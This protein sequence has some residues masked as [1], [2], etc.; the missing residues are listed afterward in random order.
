MEKTTIRVLYKSPY[1]L[2]LDKDNALVQNVAKEITY[3]YAKY[4]RPGENAT[5][6]ALSQRPAN[7]A[8]IKAL[9]EQGYDGAVQ[10]RLDVLIAKISMLM[11][12]EF[13][14]SQIYGFDSF[15]DYDKERIEKIIKSFNE[16]SEKDVKTALENSLI[17]GKDQL[18]V[19]KNV[20]EIVQK[21]Q[22][23]FENY[24]TVELKNLQLY[25]KLAHS[26]EDGNTRYIVIDNGE[27]CAEC[28]ALA[29][30][31]F[32]ISEAKIGVNC[33][34]FHPNCDGLIAVLDRDG[35]PA[36]VLGTSAELPEA[37]EIEK[38]LAEALKNAGLIGED[39]A[40]S[41]SNALK[42]SVL[43]GF[44]GYEK[45]LNSSVGTQVS[46]DWDKNIEE[47]ADYLK[48]SVNQV[49]LGNYT[50]DVT[51]LGT[52]GQ[53]A[54]GIL[55][56]DAVCDVRDFI[57]D[58]THWEWS[59][60]HI[61]Q[62]VLD[63]VAVVPIIGCF[64]YGDEIAVVLKKV[65]GNIVEFLKKSKIVDALLNSKIMKLLT[66]MLDELPTKG[67]ARL[68]TAGGPD[69]YLN[70]SLK[71]VDDLNLDKSAKNLDVVPDALK[72]TDDAA[73]EIKVAKE[74]A[75]AAK[76]EAEAAKEEIK[77][78]KK[79]SKDVLDNLENTDIFGPE[80]IEHIFEGQINKKGRAT[81]YHYNNIEGTAG[82]I[83]PE[84]KSE[85]NELGIYK[86]DVEV[87][88]VKKIRKSSF[89]PDNMNSQEVVDA[90]AEAYD[91]RSNKK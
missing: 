85:V 34:P 49:V 74:E 25:T 76:E 29:G 10:T 86:A 90:I 6:Y 59:F 9:A 50:D 82:K 19:I 37:S 87:N 39:A 88:G 13:T 65:I 55:G 23:A 16:K 15:S 32:K 28:D 78:A 44:S 46:S 24:K 18:S 91:G 75:K 38:P 56:A 26:A 30:K 57:Y 4:L 3:H 52:A 27:N 84:T 7:F 62:T 70:K 60:G 22:K 81:G 73:D 45:L 40:Q 69:D 8:Q 35:K 51:M 89:F 58:I 42:P 54:L 2:N 33:P 64:K 41:E 83:I 11:R 20:R 68:V 12:T 71:A 77:A 36:E 17:S 21:R 66:E 63:L 14:K 48:K 79:Y 43:S 80:A 31:I 72:K 67:Q 61:M 1:V 53:I 5:Y 47:L